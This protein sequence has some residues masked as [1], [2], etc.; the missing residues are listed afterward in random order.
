MV[1]EDWRGFK[2]SLGI[3]RYISINS[4]FKSLILLPALFI[5]IGT[6]KIVAYQSKQIDQAASAIRDG[7]FKRAE[8]L[9]EE[10]L[11][12][13]VDNQEARLGL[14][15]VLYKQRRY[16]D[17]YDQAAKVIV[18]NPQ[19]SRARAL[20][21]TVLLSAG[22]FRESTEQFRIALSIKENEAMAIAGL[23]MIDF[24][25]NR[26]S[27]SL[28]LLRRAISIDSLEPDHHFNFAR[29]AARAERY[30]EAADAY[31]RFLA[32]APRSD[33]ERRELIR[34]LINFL[35]Y[36]GKQRE[37]YNVTGSEE[38]SLNMEK[39]GGR[40]I[41]LLRI[42]NEK[43]PFRFVLDTGSGISVIST[44]TAKRL[45][46]KPVARGGRSRAV[47]GGGKFEIVYGFL[48]RVQLG[49]AR[50]ENVPI[51]IREFFNDREPV[52]G[53]IGLSLL[54]KFIVTVDYGNNIFKLSRTSTDSTPTSSP[55]NTK[56]S[57]SLQALSQEIPVRLTSSGFLSG[58]VNI[59]GVERAQNFIIDTGASISVVSQ[60]LSKQERLEHLAQES[61]IRVYGAAGIVENV[62]MLMLPSLRFGTHTHKNLSVAV[63]DLAPVNEATGFEQTGILGANFLRNYRVT[64]DLRKSVIQL[65]PI[66][67]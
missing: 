7:E 4:Y 22:L 26:T 59:E 54:S 9:Y 6:Y 63:L 43:I 41:I 8:K 35:R 38:V 14:S 50:I 49:E 32:V 16:Q 24:F 36:L 5:L 25:E 20:L 67:R 56:D 23:G 57:S 2:M 31:E 40:P 48:E 39:V 30:K 62:P 60:A 51:Y 44:A 66:N 55:I 13:E 65:D 29:V 58:E 47:G 18:A 27:S 28:K 61:K 52:D 15:F 17:A 64:F 33:V 10:V 42:N 37:L 12:K 19:S 1:H 34:G 21:G 11:S 45:G 3:R 46:I 53:Y